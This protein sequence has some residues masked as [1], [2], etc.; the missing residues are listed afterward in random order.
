MDK[1]KILFYNDKAALMPIDFEFQKLWRSVP[2][3]GIE[4]LM[5]HGIR[6]MHAG[7]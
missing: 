7:H 2:V 6:S 4:F 1:K 5:H 3:D